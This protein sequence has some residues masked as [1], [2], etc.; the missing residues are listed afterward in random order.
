MPYKSK[1][2]VGE[3]TKQTSGVKKIDNSVK[4]LVFTQIYQKVLCKREL[5]N[6]KLYILDYVIGSMSFEKNSCPG[7][8]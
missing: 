1:V 4:F 6:H 3:K 2:F 8:S 5:I 7:I